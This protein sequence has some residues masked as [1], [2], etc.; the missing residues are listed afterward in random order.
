MDS[1]TG[2]VTAIYPAQH[3]QLEGAEADQ[4]VFGDA[5]SLAQ[6]YVVASPLE[7]L[8]VSLEVGQVQGATVGSTYEVYRPGT[9]KLAPPEKPVAKVELTKVEAFSSEGK[10]ISGGRIAPSSRAAEREHRYCRATMRLYIDGLEASP[11][12]QSIKAALEPFKY[13]EVVNEPPICHMRLREER[14]R[15]PD[16]RRGRDHAVTRRCR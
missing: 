9:K 10:I 1:V 13:I 16:A 6:T 3:P 8:R 15:N 12:L 7:G 2:N 4:Y 14:G 11:T 5:S